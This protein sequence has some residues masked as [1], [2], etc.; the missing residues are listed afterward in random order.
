[1]QLRDEPLPLALL[2]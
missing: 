2:M 1:M